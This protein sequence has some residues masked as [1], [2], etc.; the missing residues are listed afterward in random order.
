MERGGL[1]YHRLAY[2]V[3][4]TDPCPLERNS[5]GDGPMPV[6]KRDSD[7]S[8]RREQGEICILA[9]H[10][11]HIALYQIRDAIPSFEVC[12]L[13]VVL[14]ASTSNQIVW[15]TEEKI[16]GEL[17]YEHQIASTDWSGWGF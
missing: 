16:D 1:L 10:A 9:N 12:V 15:R 5:G 8:C 14:P 6:A 17:F 13:A 2:S 11:A 4:G 7:I 3:F